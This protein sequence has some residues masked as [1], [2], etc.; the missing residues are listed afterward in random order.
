[1][2][3]KYNVISYVTL[4][5]SNLID[6]LLGILLCDLSIIMHCLDW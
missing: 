5:E 1:M 4:G 6:M 3:P 2:S